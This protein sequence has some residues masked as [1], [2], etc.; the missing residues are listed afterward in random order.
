MTDDNLRDTYLRDGV[1]VVEGLID[2]DTLASVR[3]VT[4]A[5]IDASR[6]VE[7]SDAR[8]DLDTGHSSATPRLT[9]IKLPH[10]Q[11]AVYHDLLH[12]DALYNLLTRLLGTADVRLH[13]SKLNCKAPGGGR[14]VEWHQDWAFYPHTNDNLL[15]LGIWLDDVTEDNGPL[16]AIPG[17]HRGPVLDHTRDG[18]FVGA[19]DPA[20]PG[21]AAREAR[22]LTGPAGSASVHHARTLHGSAPNHS[23]S[24]RRVLFFECCAADAWPLAGIAGPYNG[25]S[26]SALLTDLRARMVFGELPL[27]PRLA[28]VPVAMPLPPPP[29]DGSIF[30]VQQSGGAA[31][32]FNALN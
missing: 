9:R 10:T 15:A 19:I 4:D 7:H 23:S 25:L 2:A 17:S 12:S 32:A 21:F 1:A 3:Q 22:T 24:A 18:V 13:T 27:R 28:D 20:D 16:L 30:A 8:F 31:S 11:H 6:D 29:D 5:L 26:Q 14:A